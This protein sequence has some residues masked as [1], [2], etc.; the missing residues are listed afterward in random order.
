LLGG[1]PDSGR[2]PKGP[3][4]TVGFSESQ[5]KEERQSSGYK[6][7]WCQ[8]LGSSV[9]VHHIAPQAEGGSDDLDNAVTL[10]P[11]CH[12]DIGANPKKRSQLR[13]RRDWI[14]TCVAKA[15]GGPGELDLVAR[16]AAATDVAAADPARAPE[17]ADL[18]HK[19]VDHRLGLATTPL[20]VTATASN[21]VSGASGM[22]YPTRPREFGVVDCYSCGTSTLDVPGLI[23][24]PNCGRAYEEG[25]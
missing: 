24:C 3:V 25:S 9:E 6:C 10:C 22:P 14:H 12:S 13:E 1:T 21:I 19:Y 11:T 7:A 2:R 18:L 16:I 23:R 20:A 17:L 5:K 15:M 8:Q 4:G